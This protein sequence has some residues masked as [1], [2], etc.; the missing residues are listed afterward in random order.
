MGLLLIALP[1]SLQVM[2]HCYGYYGK[3]AVAF[4]QFAFALGG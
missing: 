3:V 4:F 1:H 2:E